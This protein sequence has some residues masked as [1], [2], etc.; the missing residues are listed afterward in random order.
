MFRILKLELSDVH[1]ERKVEDFGKSLSE[2]QS[3]RTIIA[4]RVALDVAKHVAMFFG[5]VHP[6]GDRNVAECTDIALDEIQAKQAHRTNEGARIKTGFKIA[7]ER[8]ELVEHA[9]TRTARVDKAGDALIHANRIRIGKAQ[10]A[11][12]VHVDVDPASAEILSGNVN[13]RR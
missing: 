4:N 12:G 13:D 1:V 7:Q 6:A 10:R 11:V 3:A 8:H 5:K 2:L 9:D